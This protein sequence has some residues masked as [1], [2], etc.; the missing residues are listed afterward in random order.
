MTYNLYRLRKIMEDFSVYYRFNPGHII[1]RSLIKVDVVIDNK[2][3]ELLKC[4]KDKDEIIDILTDEVLE[5]GVSRIIYEM[6]DPEL[7]II[8][9]ISECFYCKEEILN[10]SRV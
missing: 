2:K 5:R 4:Y 9:Q 3:R 1:N 8:Q 10:R 7:L 6:I